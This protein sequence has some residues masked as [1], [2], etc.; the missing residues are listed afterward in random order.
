M[1]QHPTIQAEW[2]ADLLKLLKGPLQEWKTKWRRTLPYFRWMAKEKLDHNALEVVN[3]IREQRMPVTAVQMSIAMTACD[4]TDYGWQVALHLLQSATDISEEMDVVVYNSAINACKAGGQWQAAIGLIND[5]TQQRMA[6][7]Q[8]SCS[9]AISACAK[10]TEW[11]GAISILSSMAPLSVQTNNDFCFT[12]AAAACAET[13]RWE[14]AL[15]LWH[16]MGDKNIASPEATY[17]TLITACGKGSEWKQA[18]EILKL[19]IEAGQYSAATYN[20]ACFAC[21]EAG[22]WTCSLSLL[23]GSFQQFTRDRTCFNS[24]ITACGRSF[25]WQQAVEVLQRLRSTLGIDQISLAATI[26]ACDMGGQWQVAVDLL[27]EAVSCRMVTP[28][29]FT[30]AISACEGHWQKALNLFED[31][32][33]LTLETRVHSFG[34]LVTVCSQS[35]HWEVAIDLLEEMSRKDMVPDGVQVGIVA[36]AVSQEKGQDRSRLLL[37]HFQRIWFAGSPTPMNTALESGLSQVGARGITLLGVGCG[38]AALD[39][40]AGIRTEK[41]FQDFEEILKLHGCKASTVSRLD[42]PTSGVLPIVLDHEDSPTGKWY[43]ACFAGRL[44][45]KEY[46]CMCEGPSLGPVGT[47]GH[48]DLPLTTQQLSGGGMLTTVSETGRAARTEYEVLKRF[49]LQSPPVELMYLRVHPV[50]G[51]THQI[52]AHLAAMGRPLIGDSKYGCA[53]SSV[54]NAPRLFLHCHKVSLPDVEGRTF[55]A[56]AD[57]PDDLKDLVASF[58]EERKV[59]F[60]NKWAWDP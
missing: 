8:N 3:L 37:S 10:S 58:E 57:L 22:M 29:S 24:A 50:T 19:A 7:N 5:M 45:S 46:L 20:V 48:T 14:A 53:D 17:I 33:R 44:V 43:K 31:M 28:Q 56:M 32:T 13:S 26:S 2:E 52:R 25:Q 51:R 23:D 47:E 12:A 38:I 40:P 60:C 35:G 6:C 55:S 41:L 21:G 54:E 15:S 16:G 39:K 34:A 30:S 59:G 18:L 27:R 36:E 49:S 9:A 42:L 1:A 11:Q 4:S